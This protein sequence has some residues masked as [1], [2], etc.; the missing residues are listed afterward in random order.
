MKRQLQGMTYVHFLYIVQCTSVSEY[1]LYSLFIV[2]PLFTEI[3]YRRDGGKIFRV[4]QSGTNKRFEERAAHLERQGKS[5][6]SNHHKYVFNYLVFCHGGNS[7]LR[8][9]KFSITFDPQR[10]ITNEYISGLKSDLSREN[11]EKLTAMYIELRTLFKDLCI[12]KR[13]SSSHSQVL[14]LDSGSKSR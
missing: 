3:R 10:Q 6:T 14:I 4:K 5:S 12:L 8:N 1:I 7:C 13:F 11:D 2:P 9:K